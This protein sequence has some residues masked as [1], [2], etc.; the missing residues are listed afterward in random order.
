MG[1]ALVILV[2][3]LQAGLAQAAGFVIGVPPIHSMRTLAARYEPLRAGLEARLGQPVHLESAVDFAAYHAHTLR[4]DYDLTITPAHFA[5]LAQKDAGFY[6]LIQFQPDH[7]AL[8]VFNAD[9]PLGTLDRLKNQQ[10]AVIDRLAV[11]V[12]ATLAYLRERGLQAGRDYQMVEYSNHASVGRA[13]INGQAMAGVTTTHGLKQ[14]P[15]PMRGK[16]KV[17]AHIADIPA[18]VMLAKPNTP[19]QE[20]ER[21]QRAVLGFAQSKTGRAFLESIAYAD[22]VPAEERLLKRVDAYLKETRK[23][24]AP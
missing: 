12:M 8:L 14:I 19:R 15:E 10:L 1:R 23:G 13:L 22:L 3:L 18:F 4:G 5:R 21:M 2:L 16:L 6:P 24:L 9:R 20:I 17:H 11:T 7:D